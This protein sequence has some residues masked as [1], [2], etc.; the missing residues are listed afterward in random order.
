MK[1][2]TPPHFTGDLVN[3]DQRLFA[4][5][6]LL[7]LPNICSIAMSLDLSTQRR[8][9]IHRGQRLLT[10]RTSPG[11]LPA[12]HPPASRAVPRPHAKAQAGIWAAKHSPV[13]ASLLHTAGHRDSTW[14]LP[15]TD[16]ASASPVFSSPRVPASICVYET[17]GEF[18]NCW[19][20]GPLSTQPFWLDNPSCSHGH[21]KC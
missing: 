8:C 14:F 17:L 20:Q 11:P 3:D 18:F 4:D 2:H 9:S 19:C 1:L 10:S 15:R 5:Y 21:R 7:F 13:L 6:Y 12:L 16:P